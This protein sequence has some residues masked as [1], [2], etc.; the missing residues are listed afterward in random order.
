MKRAYKVA[1]LID[2]AFFLKRY[3]R[4]FPGGENH[5]SEKIADN[6]YRMALRHI[7]KSNELY[8]IYYYDCL[9]LSKKFHSLIS[10]RIIDFQKDP[11]SISRIEIFDELK[12]KRKLALRLGQL[13]ENGVWLID[14]EL[15]KPLLQKRITIDDLN[16]KDVRLEIRQKGVD[17][18]IGI[19]IATLAYKKLVDRIIL[20]SGDADFVPASKLARIE[21][22]DFILDPLWNPIDGKLLEHVDGIRSTVPKPERK[23]A[24]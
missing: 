22:I 2:G 15:T 24:A 18:K 11:K 7:G 17:M 19:D 1:V 9:P 6:L 12:H 16:E 23:K 10:Q 14:P 13:K 5:S 20:I 4:I 8:R 3:T 21:G